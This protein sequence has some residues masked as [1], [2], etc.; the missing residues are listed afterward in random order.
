LAPPSVEEMAAIIERTT[1]GEPPI[2][3]RIVDGR[4]ILEM[5]QIARNV[6]IPDD[7]RRWAAS[8]AAAT[9]PSFPQSPASVR[10]YVRYGASPRGA[11]AIVMAAKARAAAE[12]R[13]AVAAGDLRAVAHAALR[14]RII[15]NFAGQA[16]GI[17][18]DR[19]IDDILAPSPAS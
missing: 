1:E 14:H 12:G 15:L 5:R 18:T 8:L 7:L 2:I 9:H 6:H 4:R 10:Q 11:Q 17:S 16:D 13:G 19:L 3:A